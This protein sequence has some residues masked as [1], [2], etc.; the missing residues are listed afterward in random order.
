[1]RLFYSSLLAC[2]LLFTACKSD[3]KPAKEV[4]PEKKEMTINEDGTF[5]KMSLAQWSLHEPILSGE[6]SPMDFAKTAKELGFEGIE[7]VSTLYRP[8]IKKYATLEE[9]FDRILV[10]LKLK[11]EQYGVENL[12]IMVDDEGDLAS[13]DPKEIARAIANHSMWIDVAEYLGCHSIRVNLFGNDN[14]KREWMYR[15]ARNLER[16]ALYAKQKNINIIVENHGGFSSNAEMLAKVIADVGMDNC[17]TL[18]DFGNFCLERE[19]GERWGAPCVKEYDK[20]K[21]VAQLMPQAKAVSAKS[22]AFDEN[23]NETTIDYTKML[24]I[25]K[26]AG[27][28][29]YIGVE[30][31][32]D[33]EDPK[34]GIIATRELLIKAANAIK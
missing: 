24:E 23:G 33:L 9:A 14:D 8:E 1:M 32:G 2:T 5:F 7:Y 29:G 25:V 27:Y 12:I 15:S 10:P 22:Y 34:E 28:N 21:G 6:M 13:S 3:P 30:Y 11:S 26:E 31:E 20:Y 4:V 18:P 17:G 16:L 19:G